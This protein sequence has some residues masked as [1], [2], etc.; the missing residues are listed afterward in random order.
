M[1]RR[2]F[3]RSGGLGLLAFSL[4]G[5]QVLLTPR[6]ARAK[7][8]PLQVLSAEEASILETLGETMLPGA[9]EAGIVQYVDHQLAAPTE[10]SLLI[11]RYLDVP[12]PWTPVYQAVLAAAAGAAR[13][14]YDM[15]LTELPA[16]KVHEFVGQMASGSVSGWQGP[17]AGMAYFFLRNDAVDV[18]Y[19]TPE[20][21]RRLDFPYMAHIKPPS[22]W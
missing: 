13:S 22:P 10:E 17:P 7:G 21:Y 19:G 6:E 9:R 16:E 18:V 14:Q 2:E 20:G 3:I 5:T 11:I 15:E 1:E 4:G 12:P 8:V